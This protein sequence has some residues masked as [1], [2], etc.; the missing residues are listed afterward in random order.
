MCNVWVYGSVAESGVDPAASAIASAM[1]QAGHRVSLVIVGDGVAQ[2]VHAMDACCA[3]RV[4]VADSEV[5]AHGDVG[6]VAAQLAAMAGKDTPD[7]VLFPHTFRERELAARL[8]Q[9]TCMPL[10]TNVRS[11]SVEKGQMVVEKP[12]FGGKVVATQLIAG[13]TVMATIQLG[14]MAVRVPSSFSNFD[15]VDE[16]VCATADDVLREFVSLSV[17][18]SNRPN[19]ADASIVVTAGRGVGSADGVKLVEQ[20]A[21]CLGAAVGATRFVVDEGWADYQLQVGQTGKVVQPNIY[22]ACGVS[23]AI[24]HI[25]GMSSSKCI[26]AINADETAPIFKIADFGIVGDCRTIIP[27]LI[28]QLE[29]EAA[30]PISLDGISSPTMD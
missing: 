19:L 15:V 6:S 1:V 7:A 8:A 23:G 4:L 11:A 18:K 24:Q 21:D 2:R 30:A 29:D 16:E 28:K 20:L 26:V 22:I 13:R 9:R 17:E 3:S 10:I 14:A 25:A 27:E 5:F 12:L